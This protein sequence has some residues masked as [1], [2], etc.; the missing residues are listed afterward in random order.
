[1]RALRDRTAGTASVGSGASVELLA[2]NDGRKW[3]Q[4]SNPNAVGLW[5]NFGAPAVIGSGPYVAPGGGAYVI[6]KDNLD[7]GAVNGIMASGGD[8]AVGTMEYS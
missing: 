3:A 8:V 7:L 5:L 1:M 2:A 6:D 4:I